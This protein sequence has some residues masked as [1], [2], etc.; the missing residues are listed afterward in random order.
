MPVRNS[1]F[2]FTKNFKSFVLKNCLPKCKKRQT[3]Y[4]CF[5][6][7][8]SGTFFKRQ[9]LH[10]HSILQLFKKGCFYYFVGILVNL[11]ISEII[12]LNIN[13]EESLYLFYNHLHYYFHCHPP[14]QPSSSLN[15]LLSLSF[16]ISLSLSLP[17]SL[18][19]SLLSSISLSSSSSLL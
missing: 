17:L 8:D 15:L 19:L 4:F 16:F 5:G 11:Y 1:C 12:F 3:S 7:I 10:Q 6:S 18:S 9:L 13:A 14:T 2:L